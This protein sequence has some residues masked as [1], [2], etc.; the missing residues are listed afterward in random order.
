MNVSKT[1]SPHEQYESR[2]SCPQIRDLYHVF[3]LIGIIIYP[4]TLC[5][6]FLAVFASGKGE[7]V[8]QYE[9]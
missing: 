7:E 8:V 5:F 1:T 9:A 4:S 3:A 6:L 2:I